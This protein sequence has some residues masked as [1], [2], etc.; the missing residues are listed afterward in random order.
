[1]AGSFHIRRGT[2]PG[3]T[4]MRRELTQLAAQRSSYILRAIYA[5]SLSILG[6]MVYS[7]V[8]RIA[9]RAWAM[10]QSYGVGRH[11]LQGVTVF[12]LVSIAAVMPAMVVGSVTSEREQGTL[13]LMRISRLS[14]WDIVL[15]KYFARL[16]PFCTFLLLLVPF[17]AVAYSLGGVS[18]GDI[19]EVIATLLSAVL[20]VAAI[21]LFCSALCRSTLAAFLAAYLSL[22]VLYAALPLLWLWLSNTFYYFD[23]DWVELWILGPWIDNSPST[24]ETIFH[25]GLLLAGLW[26]CLAVTRV[27]LARPVRQRGA[28]AKQMHRRY[29][30]L[31]EWLNQFV[32]GVHWGSSKAT[33]PDQAPVSW[34]ERSRA[35]VCVPRHMFRLLCLVSV[36]TVIILMFIVA[37]SNRF[38]WASSSYHRNVDALSVFLMFLWLPAVLI[39]AVYVA[40]LISGERSDQTLDVL[41]TT[42]LEP[43]DILR[44]KMA[45]VPRVVFLVAL[46]MVATVLVEFWGEYV[47]HRMLSEGL[48][49]LALALGTVF[50]YEHLVVWIAM[51]SSLR[52]RRRSVVVLLTLIWILAFIL[53]PPLLVLLLSWAIHGTPFK[54]EELLFMSPVGMFVLTEFHVFDDDQSYLVAGIIGLVLY[55]VTG[56]GIRHFCLTRASHLLHRAPRV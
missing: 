42:P 21:A 19:F 9:A 53:I 11:L 34:R 32:G 17:G 39:P 22:F 14:A 29:D 24:G 38:W 52:T 3:L 31:V 26:G 36:P 54:I 20:R 16:V 51:Q 25:A 12:A 49:Y 28:M 55:F 10:I 41:L 47:C 13:D 23:D 2:L 15:Q 37:L 4:V 6:L 8:T 5:L 18:V 30:R 48:I 40:N 33:L 50:I 27:L 7:S 45:A 44:Q 1:M 43:R 35:A 56:M 46:P